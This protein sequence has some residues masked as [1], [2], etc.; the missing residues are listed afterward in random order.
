MKKDIN[1]ELQNSDK[2]E[3]NRQKREKKTDKTLMIAIGI[4]VFVVI[5]IVGIITIPEP[6]SAWIHLERT[7]SFVEDNPELLVLIN[8]TSETVGIL[9][10]REVV[11]KDDK[12][13]DFVNVLSDVLKNTKYSD[14]ESVYVGIWKRKIV[15][16]SVTDEIALYAD[17]NGIYIENN[18]RLIEYSVREEGRKS[19]DSLLSLMEDHLNEE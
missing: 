9:N 6:L 4:C 8:S 15:L 13:D 12:A 2:M 7:E 14:T 10:D 16:Y 11:L 18:G 5:F 3:K 19:L 17:K 1:K